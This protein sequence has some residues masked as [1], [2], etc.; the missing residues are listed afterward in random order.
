M[1][2]AIT[3]FAVGSAICGAAKNMPM[4]IGGRSASR[5]RDVEWLA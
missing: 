2:V 3:I 5:Y 1:L 4:L